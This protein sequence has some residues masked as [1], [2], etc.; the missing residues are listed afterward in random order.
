MNE[1][2]E[3]KIEM[4]QVPAGI[5]ERRWHAPLQ[6][7]RQ[8]R[9][10]AGALTAVA[11]FLLLPLVLPGRTYTGGYVWDLMIVYDG[12]QRVIMG[13]VPNR[14]FH[15]PLGPL[16][17]LLLAGGAWLSATAGGMM[18][19]VT[20]I[21]ALLILP[22]LLYTCS[23]RL[24]LLLALGFGVH[25][26][27]LVIAPHLTGDIGISPTYGMFYN[28]FGWALLSLLILFALPHRDGFGGPAPDAI[29]LAAIWSIMFYLKASYAAVGGAYLLGLLAFPHARR[30]AVMAIAASA[31]LVLVVE[32]LWGGTLAYIADLRAAGAVSGAIQG[33]LRGLGKTVAENVPGLFLFLCVVLLVLVRGVGLRYLLIAG[34]AASAGILVAN[35]NFGGP[36]ILI[37]FPAALVLLL[38]PAPSGAKQQDSIPLGG[39]LLSAAMIVPSD[40]AALY[41]YA[42][43]AK[44]VLRGRSDDPVETRF[45]NL[46]ARDAPHPVSQ[47]A[48]SPE[49]RHGCGS[50]DPTVLNLANTSGPVG[51]LQSQY[52]ETIRDGATV[53]TRDPALSGKV[54]T[55]DMA[56][57]FNAVLR[58]QPLV[59]GNQFYHADRTFSIAS[60]L[61]AQE[62]FGGAEVVM[63]PKLPVNYPTF[64]YMRRLYGSYLLANYALV[65]RSA[66]WDV[67]RRR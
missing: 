11:V 40:F 63:I 6:P 56:N 67:Y 4:V 55:F 27:I 62:A 61:P 22:L 43:Y 34:F 60:H 8:W 53:L 35:Q 21:F 32:F 13:Q 23:S 3:E 59:G 51:R 7:G 41:N 33:G 25:I 39:L 49:S 64:D 12:A 24:P 42:G 46:I 5:L 28:R 10:V 18:P 15:T 31:L 38:A 36:G 58:R 57:P 20:G 65:T 17:Y 30:A 44:N 66:C 52:L 50:T 1:W 48:A 14:E 54:F 29:V 45:N 37:L 47:A 9:F 26:I 16:L 2:R 19:L